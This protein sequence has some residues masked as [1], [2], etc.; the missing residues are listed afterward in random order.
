MTKRRKPEFLNCIECGTTLPENRNSRQMYCC[1]AHARAY[2]KANI[3]RYKNDGSYVSADKRHYLGR[4]RNKKRGKRQGL[5]L[6]FLVQLWEQQGGRCAISGIPM[7]HIGGKGRIG[8]NA[9]IDQIV[10]GKGYLE[11]N[12]QLVTC[13]INRIKGELT[14]EELYDLCRTILNF[15]KDD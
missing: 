10:A 5:S 14:M 8:T 6:E 2:R 4:L 15:G 11:D 13:D 1:N 3:D 12:V 9:S 7:T